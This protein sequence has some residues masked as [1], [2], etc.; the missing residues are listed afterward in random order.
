MPESQTTR[1][2]PRSDDEIERDILYLLTDRENGPPL[3]TIDEIGAA[4][5]RR[6][7]V[8]H[9]GALLRHGVAHETADGFVF[10]SLA[11]VRV[12]EITGR[13]V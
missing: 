11:G 6:D 13:V 9:V 7:A 12:V 3:W 5:E 4:I 10:A 1:D 8:D 2:D